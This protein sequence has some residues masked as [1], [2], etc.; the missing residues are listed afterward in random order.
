LSSHDLTIILDVDIT[1]TPIMG[2][3]KPLIHLRRADVSQQ[4]PSPKPNKFVNKIIRFENLMTLKQAYPS[5]Y[6]R[7]QGAFKDSMIH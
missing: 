4:L 7:V 1:I 2:I 6:Q 3:D 5:E